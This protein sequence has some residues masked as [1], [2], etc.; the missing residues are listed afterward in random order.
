[1]EKGLRR[2]G[3]IILAD[4]RFQLG[5]YEL[6][7]SR[8]SDMKKYGTL[9]TNNILK[10]RKKFTNMYRKRNEDPNSSHFYGLIV[11]RKV[12]KQMVLIIYCC[13]NNYLKIIKMVMAKESKIYL[14]KI[15]FKKEI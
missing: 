9:K 11:F 1:M 7:H 14:V 8:L 6:I 4:V 10:V 3:K 13:F 5:S 15:F 2:S 12:R